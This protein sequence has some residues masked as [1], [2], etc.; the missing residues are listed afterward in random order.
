MGNG[1]SQHLPVLVEDFAEN[2]EGRVGATVGGGG[3]GGGGGKRVAEWTKYVE[4]LG[5]VVTFRGGAAEC[6]VGGGRVVCP[7]HDRGT[8][9]VRL[10]RCRFGTLM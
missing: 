1:G 9:Y 2:G 6:G 7:A 4:A 10:F 3:G 8:T 5:R